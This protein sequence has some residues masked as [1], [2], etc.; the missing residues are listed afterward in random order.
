MK[1]NAGWCLFLL[2]ELWCKA[3]WGYEDWGVAMS[4]PASI[5]FRDTGSACVHIVSCISSPPSLPLPLSLPSPSPPLLTLS[6][7]GGISF[8]LGQSYI[9]LAGATTTECIE[10]WD[11]TYCNDSHPVGAAWKNSYC[12]M[13]KDHPPY[14]C[15]TNIPRSK[16]ESFSLSFGIIEFAYTVLVFVLVFVFTRLC[17]TG[18]STSSTGI[19]TSGNEGFEGFSA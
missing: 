4:W 1:K 10:Q 15:T 13:Y 16:L 11:A 19:S 18:I 3:I 5:S 9:E 6:T 14:S 2:G 17:S 12:A 7:S 8:P